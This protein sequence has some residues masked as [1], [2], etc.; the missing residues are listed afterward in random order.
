[1]AWADLSNGVKIA[2]IISSISVFGWIISMIVWGV[3]KKKAEDAKTEADK[4]S[5]SDSQEKAKQA[6]IAMGVIALLGY[7]IAGGMYYKDTKTPASEV[8]FYYF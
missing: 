5:A 1:M 4:K 2:I 3:M 8:K 7:M 6:A